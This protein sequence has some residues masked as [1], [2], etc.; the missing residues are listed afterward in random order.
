VDVLPA[1]SFQNYPKDYYGKDDTGFEDAKKCHIKIDLSESK[2]SE[3]LLE[4]TGGEFDLV[5]AAHLQTHTPRSYKETKSHKDMF[6]YY[7]R[8]EEY[9]PLLKGGGVLFEVN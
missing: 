8:S 9:L 3:K 7:I 2:S 5:T 6:Y 1:D 4:I